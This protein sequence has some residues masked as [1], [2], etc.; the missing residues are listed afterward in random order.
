MERTT[1]H[2]VATVERSR[3]HTWAKGNP[4]RLL[5]SA[6]MARFSPPG[7]LRAFEQSSSRRADGHPHVTLTAGS[8]VWAVRGL[9]PTAI[10]LY[11][12]DPG[13]LT[14]PH[15]LPS[16]QTPPS[17]QERAIWVLRTASL[18]LAENTAR[19]MRNAKQ[20]RC[21]GGQ[22]VDASWSDST[23]PP[24]RRVIPSIH[25]RVPNC[26]RQRK[27]TYER[28]RGLMRCGRVR[29]RTHPVRPVRQVHVEDRELLRD[30]Q[31][32]AAL[33]RLRSG[34]VQVVRP[35]PRQS[36]PGTQGETQQSTDA[37]PSSYAGTSSSTRRAATCAT[38]CR[39]FCA[40]LTMTSCYPV[41]RPVSHRG[42]VTF[43]LQQRQELGSTIPRTPRPLPQSPHP[44]PVCRRLESLRTVHHRCR[45]Q[46]SQEVEVLWCACQPAP[47]ASTHSLHPPCAPAPHAG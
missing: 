7:S 11:C 26:D 25:S 30:Q 23:F 34:L 42:S 45:Q 24:H 44:H 31:A 41:R 21:L 39:C 40:W 1:T 28:R 20:L 6:T 14:T 16:V 18:P 32:R 29:Y 36:H 15:A 35:S 38:T 27:V 12:A 3:V 4:Q 47:P 13:P 19:G 2:I 9:K 5:P 8:P 17:D 10:Y 46:G 22:R 33:Q 43:D 37:V